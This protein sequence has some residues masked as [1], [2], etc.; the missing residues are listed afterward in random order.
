M[1]TMS[2]DPGTS[3]GGDTASAPGIIAASISVDTASVWVQVAAAASPAGVKPASTAPSV[4]SSHRRWAGLSGAS[5]RR[6]PGM[7]GRGCRGIVEVSIERGRRDNAKK[8]GAGKEGKRKVECR[9]ERG[10][11]LRWNP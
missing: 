10:E 4:A 3:E 1:S 9:W 7:G 8:N 11:L 6:A 5:A 2:A